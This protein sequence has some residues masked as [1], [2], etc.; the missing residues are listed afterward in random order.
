MNYDVDAVRAQFP[1]LTRREG[2]RAAVFFDNPA[3]TQIARMAIDRMVESMVHRNANLGGLF[4]T[5]VLAVEDVAEAHRAAADFVN[6][7]DPDEIFFGQNMTTLTF[8]LSRALGRT[9]RPGDEIVVTRMDHDANVSPW[10]MLAEDRGLV[11]RWL[12]FDLDTYEFDLARLRSLLSERTRLVAVGHASNLTGTVNDIAAISRMA[13]EVG[14]LVYVDAVQYAPHGVIDV[15]ALGCDFL[16][17]SAYKF[18]GPH[19]GLAWGRRDLLEGLTAYKVRPAKDT[20][21]SKFVT[22]TTNREELAGIR[23]AIEY[24]AWVGQQFGK[25]PGACRRNQIIAGIG[26]MADH[27]LALTTRLIAGLR[28]LDGIRIY[29]ITDPAAFGRRVPTVSF[30]AAGVATEAIARHMAGKGIYLWHGHNYAIEPCRAMGIL[31]D[32]GVVR[33]GLAHYNTPEEVDWFLSVLV[34]FLKSNA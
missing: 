24:Y 26:A 31:D 32:G 13:H 6:A 27:D 8:A 25:V 28:A 16:V 5:S 7:R 1:G 22:G 33:V 19:Y 9:F 4:T 30:R 34:G 11:V 21:P 2:D 17:C 20:L 14:A 18:F 3:G 23:G 10:L 15:Q 12:D 29:G